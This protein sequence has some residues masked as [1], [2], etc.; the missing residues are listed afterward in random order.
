VFQKN[1]Q[2]FH[3]K[4]QKIQTKV[5][6]RMLRLTGKADPAE[7]NRMGIHLTELPEADREAAAVK[8]F[9]AVPQKY[10]PQIHRMDRPI[11]RMRLIRVR[12]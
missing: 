12:L 11:H 6:D 1:H 3:L 2:V 8:L 7:K 5:A 4:V 9:M 10:P